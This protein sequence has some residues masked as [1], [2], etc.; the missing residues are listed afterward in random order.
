MLVSFEK[1]KGGKNK[2]M[3]FQEDVGS[4]WVA[5]TPKPG[6]FLVFLGLT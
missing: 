2:T 6:G 1:R 5:E 3:T 4:S